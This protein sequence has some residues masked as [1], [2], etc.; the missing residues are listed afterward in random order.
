MFEPAFLAHKARVARGKPSCLRDYAVTNEAEYFAV[1][2][3]VFF[4][5]P[6]ALSDELPEVYA[7]LRD[8]YGLDLAARP[9]RPK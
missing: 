1:A 3:E 5:Q 2:T 7:A 4:E 6:G 8:F 9:A